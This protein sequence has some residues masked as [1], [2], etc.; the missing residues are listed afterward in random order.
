M[1]YYYVAYTKE[2][3]LVKGKV[4]AD[5]E[6]AAT[7]LLDYG[8]YRVVTLKGLTPAF[9]IGKILKFSF[10]PPVQKRELVMFSRQLALL[11][12]SGID[13]IR[14]LEL[15]Q[16]QM[17]N[18]V[19]REVITTVI[20]DVRDGKS[21]SAALSKHTKIFPKMYYRAMAAG[22]QGGNLGIILRQMADFMERSAEAGKKLK[23]AMTYPI[24]VLVVAVLVIGVLVTFVLPAFTGLF[25]TFGAELPIMTRILF[26]IGDFFKHFG[27]YI[28]LAIVII[29]VAGFIYIRTPRGAYNWDK[30]SLR[31]PLLGRIN[32]LNQLSYCCRIMALLF[33]VGIPPP[34]IMTLAT[35]GI[36]NRV[37]SEALTEVREE[38][39][40]GEGISRP[41]SKKPVFL[42]LMVQMVGVGEETGN[43]DKVLT[44]V[45]ESYE[46]EADDRTRSAVGMIQPA[47]TIILGGIVAFIALA[48]VQTMYGVYGQIGTQ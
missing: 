35:E 4:S 3:K 10:T 23:S 16:M 22:E 30:L 25:S 45:A 14:A 7:S 24:I 42:P 21:L 2:K 44:T 41:M 28:L 6:Q 33:R 19:L 34:E 38:L 18:R 13:I 26:G 8:G 1:N 47:M 17:N 12:E 11:I 27:L 36:T 20:D 37:V 32:L 5:N 40:R 46:T 15:L 29:I 31:L 39:I 43:L 9:D 48:L